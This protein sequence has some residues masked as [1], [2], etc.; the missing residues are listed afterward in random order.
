M[1]RNLGLRCVLISDPGTLGGAKT[2]LH[3]PKAVSYHEQPH[4]QH[5]E[6]LTTFNL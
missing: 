6:V 5:K 4:V 2:R 1:A 3:T